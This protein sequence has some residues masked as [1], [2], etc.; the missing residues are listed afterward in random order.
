MRKNPLIHLGI[1]FC[2]ILLLTIAVPTQGVSKT[3]NYEDNTE[4]ISSN[5]AYFFTFAFVK[6]EYENRSKWFAYFNLWNPDFT[7][8]IDVLGYTAWEH[9]FYSVKAYEVI[10]SSRI[11]FIGRHHCYIFAWG[12]SGVTVFTH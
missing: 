5:D 3:I 8:T 1:I 7:N 12:Y 2:L 9:K 4:S 6:G 11:G 10:G